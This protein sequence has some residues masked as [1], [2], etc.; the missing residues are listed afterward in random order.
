MMFFMGILRGGAAWPGDPLGTALAG[1][2]RGDL[3]ARL[4]E[5]MDDLRAQARESGRGEW[6]ILTLPV[7]D[8]GAVQPIRLYLR[9]GDDANGNGSEERGARFVVDLDLSRLGP[10]QLDGLVRRGR[11]DLVLRSHIPVTPDMKVEL[12]TIFRASL[13]GAGFAGDIAFVTTPRFPVK[14]LEALRPH[15]GVEA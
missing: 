2:G 5:D 7:L 3:R 12:G 15:I 10:L 11:F 6:R 4:A 14:P 8:E 9:G 1:A 13:E